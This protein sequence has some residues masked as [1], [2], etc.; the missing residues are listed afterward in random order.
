MGLL[1]LQIREPLSSLILIFIFTPPTLK[2]GSMGIN[3]SSGYS[4]QLSQIS[5]YCLLHE[6]TYLHSTG[7][8][9]LE[10]PG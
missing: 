9:P 1:S 5:H 6:F 4:N 8:L 10:N 2:L 3:R 7:P